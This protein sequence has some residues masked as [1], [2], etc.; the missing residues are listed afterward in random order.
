MTPNEMT[1]RMGREIR[2][3]FRVHKYLQDEVMARSQ[4][5]NF[6]GMGPLANNFENYYFLLRT[7]NNLI[8]DRL[9][10]MWRKL[11]IW[12]NEHEGVPQR[13][14][15]SEPRKTL[16]GKTRIRRMQ[17]TNNQL[18][19]DQTNVDPVNEDWLGTGSPD[20]VNRYEK[21]WDIFDALVDH[22]TLFTRRM[23]WWQDEWELQGSTARERQVM[24][25]V[26]EEEAS[27]SLLE[28][29]LADLAV[30]VKT[31][32]GATIKELRLRTK[33]L[34]RRPKIVGG[35]QSLNRG[36]VPPGGPVP[37]EYDPDIETVRDE[38]ELG[39]DV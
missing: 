27:F 21:F 31:E 20:V 39:E 34:K 5:P 29:V 10:E 17:A 16:Q 15:N 22:G 37:D 14:D 36:Q 24:A 3:F 26:A 12:A 18:T 23:A 13:F 6:W 1:R 32:K 7:Y 2:Q 35:I 19:L 38:P 9:N 30:L 33:Y 11:E 25:I 4:D 28:S 8:D